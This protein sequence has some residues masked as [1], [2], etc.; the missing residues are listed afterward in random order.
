MLP[1][2]RKAFLLCYFLFAERKIQLRFGFY[3]YLLFRHTPR[4]D[5]VKVGAHGMGSPFLPKER[6]K[7]AKGEKSTRG[8]RSALDRTDWHT[9]ETAERLQNPEREGRQELGPTS[10]RSRGFAG[11]C[12]LVPPLSHNLN[13][14][15][16]QQ[17][18]CIFFFK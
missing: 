1:R 14:V 6:K 11:N 9:D 13:A 7:R 3:P 8:G 2:W 18:Y 5:H 15:P 17:I 10:L 16:H 4:Y 12:F